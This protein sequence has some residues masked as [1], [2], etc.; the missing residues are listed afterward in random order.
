M[1]SGAFTKNNKNN[2]NEYAIITNKGMLRS[3]WF[4]MS[5][6]VITF[7]W[8]SAKNDNP[9]AAALKRKNNSKSFVLT[10]AGSKYIEGR[11]K[12]SGIEGTYIVKRMPYVGIK[13]GKNTQEKKCAKI[14]FIP[15][16]LFAFG[17]REYSIAR[18]IWP[19]FFEQCYSLSHSTSP[20]ISHP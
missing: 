2:T 13:R 10:S 12:S 8:C 19:R 6:V 14:A 4:S 18:G 17:P 7:F 20:L 1:P 5:M 3:R 15:I 9:G 11:L 16:V